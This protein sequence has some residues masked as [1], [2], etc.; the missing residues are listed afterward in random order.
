MKYSVKWVMWGR[1]EG[2]NAFDFRVAINPIIPLF[3]Q[4]FFLTTVYESRHP[5]FII[6]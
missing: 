4:I 2:L 1:I 6:E 5:I 3:Y